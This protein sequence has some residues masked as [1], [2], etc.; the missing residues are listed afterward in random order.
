MQESK[1]KI[2]ILENMDACCGCFACRNVCPKSAIEAIEDVEGF[3]YPQINEEKCIGCR[4]CVRTCPISRY[5]L[6]K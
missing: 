5:K 1:T 4:R 2:S 6:E 3:W